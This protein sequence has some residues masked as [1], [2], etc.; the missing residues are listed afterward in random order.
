[1]GQYVKYFAKFKKACAQIGGTLPEIILRL[2]RVAQYL[3][4]TDNT[5]LTISTF[6][7][8]LF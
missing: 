2:C 4:E 6:Y 1:V 7:L 3:L 8:F 5:S